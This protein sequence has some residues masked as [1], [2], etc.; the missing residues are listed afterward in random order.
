MEKEEQELGIEDLRVIIHGLRMST[1]SF[2]EDEDIQ[3]QVSHMI[4]ELPSPEQLNELCGKSAD[5][6]YLRDKLGYIMNVIEGGGC[7]DEAF[8]ARYE[9]KKDMPPRYKVLK[10]RGAMNKT[11]T[12]GLIKMSSFADAH[13]NP[14]IAEKAIVLAKK[15]SSGDVSEEELR[16]FMAD[17]KNAGFEREA[18][19]WMKNKWD[20]F[21]A[22]RQTKKQDKGIMQ[23]LQQTK[24]QNA[25]TATQLNLILRLMQSDDYD[26]GRLQQ[27]INQ[28]P[29]DEVKGR[30]SD[31]SNY[32][33]QLEGTF[34]TKMQ[35]LTEV[36]NGMIGAYQKSGGQ[37]FGDGNAVAPVAAEPTAPAIDETGEEDVVGDDIASAPVVSEPDA[38]TATPAAVT[39]Y[40][41]PP[42]GMNLNALDGNQKNNLINILRSAKNEYNMIVNAQ[43]AVSTT[44]TMPTSTPSNSFSP[45]V[46][47]WIQE[48][49]SNPQFRSQVLEQLG[50]GKYFVGQRVKSNS[51]GKGGTI[52]EIKT[53]GF[54]MV[55]IDGQPK[56]IATRPESVTVAKTKKSIKLS[57]NRKWIRVA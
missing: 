52:S 3:D 30:L 6:K 16:I 37:N 22:G 21:Q 28:I 1:F 12:S 40:P 41:P 14:L 54:L 51:S 48:I 34:H 38:A 2:I 45:E 49:K 27:V 35:E 57:S 17:C 20:E 53:N 50:A 42:S 46:I 56:P 23:Q 9:S 11:L 15:S 33:G 43:S 44:T 13:S 39:S 7:K 36:A 47:K 4:E 29:S 26:T 10:W 55:Q 24:E 31:F 25:K 5:L 18:Q 8:K 19:N 32:I